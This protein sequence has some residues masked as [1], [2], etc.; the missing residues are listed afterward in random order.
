M[1]EETPE[2]P[3]ITELTATRAHQLICA[4]Y[5]ETMANLIRKGAV[6]GFEFMW[7]T[8]I[9]KPIGKYVGDSSML[10]APMES[11]IQNAIADY[12]AEQAKQISVTDLTEELKEHEPC[13]GKAAEECALCSTKLS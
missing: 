6:T 7:N 3:P 10:I 12:R 13:Q 4:D 9:E 2:L 5:L 8:Q 1:S 11:K